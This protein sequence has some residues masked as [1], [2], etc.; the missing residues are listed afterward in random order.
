[1]TYRRVTSVK[2]RA[3]WASRGKRTRTERA[4]QDAGAPPDAAIA[5]DYHAPFSASAASSVRST[6]S[7]HHAREQDISAASSATMEG[8]A[9][10]PAQAG[11]ERFRWRSAGAP[12]PSGSLRRRDTGAGDGT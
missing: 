4:S 12:R 10:P 11:D 5:A 1:M 6:G 9:A 2:S 3:S 8:V 7:A